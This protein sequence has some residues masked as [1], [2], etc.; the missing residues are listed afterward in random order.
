M[1]TFDGIEVEK[2]DI[3]ENLLKGWLERLVEM[4]SKEIGELSYYFCDDE[5]MLEANKEYL[6]HDYFTDIL[7]FDAVQGD[8][9]CGDILISIDTVKTNAE[10][11]KVSFL[12]E[13]YRVLAHGVLHLLGYKD[14]TKEEQQKMR[15][16][17]DAS[18]AILKNMS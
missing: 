14:K 1:I 5:Y 10:K 17:E 8:V 16:A 13:L 4:K 6:N 2:P 11:Y 18:L 12:E 15:L 3:D 9:I 7:T